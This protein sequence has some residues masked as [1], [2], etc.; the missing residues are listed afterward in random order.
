[1]KL[2]LETD[3]HTTKFTISPLFES[4]KE[5][6]SV[7]QMSTSFDTLKNYINNLRSQ[8]GSD[9]ELLVGYEAGCIGFSLE[10]Q[11]SQINVPCAVI[12]P[13]SIVCTEINRRWKTKTDKRDAIAIAK[14]LVNGD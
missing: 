8:F 2:H 14:C 13:L 11:L 3:V 6:M 10:K 5:L 4:T 7:I 12:A 1:M 9:L